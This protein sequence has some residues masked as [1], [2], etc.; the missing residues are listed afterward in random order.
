MKKMRGL[1]L[2]RAYY[3]AW[4]APMIREKFPEYE[5]RIAVGLVGPGSEC[6][7]YDDAISTDH[8]FEA[9]F[10]LWL[11]K[12]DEDVI[13]FPLFRAYS[14][15]PE[16]FMG[17]MKQAQSFYGGNRRGVMEI[18]EFYSRFTGCP[19]VPD[20]WHQWMAVPE[21]ALAEA[22][23]GQIFRDDLGKFTAI[24]RELEKGYPEDVRLKK[25]AARAALMAQSGQYN[26]SRCISHGEWGA[27]GMALAEFVN[28]AVSMIYLLNHRYMPYYKWMFRGMRELPLLGDLS[29]SLEE[30]LVPQQSV[31][32]TADYKA[33]NLDKIEA[34]SAAVIEELRRQKLTSGAW[35]YLEPHALELTEHIRNGEI[36][37]LH[38][39]E[40]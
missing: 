18:G 19:G 15:L 36:R 24:R 9:G 32:D 39:M 8:D 27:A 4:G 20:D 25:M 28:N 6:F 2:S 31:T 21:Y 13:G 40:G 14:K 35:D 7:G 26:Y 22:V 33:R 1:E 3:E 29:E 10:C 11:T 23:N 5:D 30:L 16:E 12:E 37:N 34:V 17:V 38:L